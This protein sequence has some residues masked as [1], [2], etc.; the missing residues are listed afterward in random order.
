MQRVHQLREERG[1]IA[2]TTAARSFVQCV[3]KL[4]QDALQRGHQVDEQPRRVV[5]VLVQGQ[6]SDT[7]PTA[8]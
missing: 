3:W 8:L 2:F 1:H 4:G 7:I 6:P 5:V